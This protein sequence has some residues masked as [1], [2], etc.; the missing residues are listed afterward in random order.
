M[1]VQ[2][3]DFS[4]P[5]H[6]GGRTFEVSEVEALLKDGEIGPLDGFISKMGRPFSSKLR[7]NDEFKLEFDFGNDAKESDE[8]VDVSNYLWL[9][10]SEVRL[11]CL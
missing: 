2:S 6:P 1:L 8:P 5:K 11:K 7:L 10:M 4:L 3:D 9:E